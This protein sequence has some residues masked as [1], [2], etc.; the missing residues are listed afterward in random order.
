MIDHL[1]KD[2][3]VN[4]IFNKLNGADL[5]ALSSTNKALFGLIWAN[6]TTQK[7]IF[8]P[9]CPN[10][11]KMALSVGRIVFNLIQGERLDKEI[12][13]LELIIMPNAYSRFS[14]DAWE[15]ECR[16]RDKYGIISFHVYNYHYEIKY[17]DDFSDLFDV[18][19]LYDPI[20]DYKVDNMFITLDKLFGQLEYCEEDYNEM[21]DKYMQSMYGYS[22]TDTTE[23]ESTEDTD[24]DS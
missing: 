21:K 23:A 12:L 16:S 19:L 10:T 1:L 8:G 14:M 7:A 22:T 5:L 4:H 24:D 15:H 3:L 6:M 9:K 18:L 13:F 11:T 17:E 20:D 2:I